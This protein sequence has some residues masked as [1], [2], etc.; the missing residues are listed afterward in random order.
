M[1]QHHSQEVISQAENKV[2][3]IFPILVSKF[4][5]WYLCTLITEWPQVFTLPRL[6]SGGFIIWHLILMYRTIIVH[7][8]EEAHSMCNSLDIVLYF[9]S[10]ER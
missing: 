2:M 7:T 8:N 1:Y 9:G 3:I 4:P 6:L 5:L 10:F